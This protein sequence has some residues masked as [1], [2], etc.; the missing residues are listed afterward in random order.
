MTLIKT[1]REEEEAERSAPAEPCSWVRLPH[2]AEGSTVK[3]LQ[4]GAWQTHS[5]SGGVDTVVT[6]P[7]ETSAGSP[8]NCKEAVA[9][10]HT[11]RVHTRVLT[12]Q[13]RSSLPNTLALWA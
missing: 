8:R 9:Q 12:A 1:A 10:V 13:H 4:E 2:A 6:K 7:P 5:K 3:E 11:Q